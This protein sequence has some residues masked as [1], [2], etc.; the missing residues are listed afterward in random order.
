[1]FKRNWRDIEPIS[2]YDNN[3][4]VRYYFRRKDMLSSIGGYKITEYLEWVRH[5]TIPFGKKLPYQRKNM[6][7]ILYVLQGEGIL[8]VGNTKN[9]IKAEDAVYIPTETPYAIY[10]TVESQPIIYMNY[11]IRTPPDA[12]EVK[13]K[14]MQYDEKVESNIRIE[15][16]MSKKPSQSHNG[17]CTTYSL[18]TRDMMKY[19]LFGTMMSVPGVL[20][21]HRHNSEAIYFI[22]SGLGYAKVG[23]EELPIR[24]GDAVY[25]NPCFAHMCRTSLKGQPLNVFCQGVAVPFDA[26]LWTIEDLPDLQ[27]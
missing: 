21:Y 9:E 22:S 27:I 15:R 6:E 19:L 13:I 5:V 26:K 1:L 25:I 12:L 8:Q 10:P 7:E 20:G 23:G 2:E 11:G 16:W 4:H 24:D 18:F 14:S 3:C 17:T